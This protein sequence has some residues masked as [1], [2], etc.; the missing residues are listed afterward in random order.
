MH[1][2]IEYTCWNNLKCNT[3]ERYTPCFK[4]SLFVK[5]KISLFALLLSPLK[6]EIPVRFCI[7]WAPG[8]LR[9]FAVWR[10][11]R[12]CAAVHHPSRSRTGQRGQGGRGGQSFEQSPSEKR[13][14][15][16][17]RCRRRR[18]SRTDSPLLRPVSW[19]PLP[20]SSPPAWQW[21]QLG[22]N[23][24]RREWPEG[25]RCLQCF[26]ALSWGPLCVAV[27]HRLA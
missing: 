27:L 11:G 20:G 23:H 9:W 13:Q 5:A 17:R 26:A 12:G 15:K 7:E 10:W 14:R 16:R 2:L 24:G 18:R 19:P 4:D 21:Y 6:L 8:A 25:L 1:N 22:R 3:F